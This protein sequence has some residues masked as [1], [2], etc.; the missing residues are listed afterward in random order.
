MGST[1]LSRMA[2]RNLWRSPRRSGLTLSSIAF[3][4]LLAVL[5][6]GMGDANFSA[7]IDLA[8]R[9][10]GGH[11]A[12]QNVR[13]LDAPTLTHAIAG[14]QELRRAVLQDP[15]VAKVVVRVTGQ[16]MLQT[17]E[18]SYGAAYLAIDPA[19]EDSQTLS[20]LD[21]KIEGELFQS[22]AERGIILG[23]RLADNLE[24]GLGRK[25]VYLLTDRHG[26]I[27]RDVARVTATLHTGSPSVDAGLCL[28]PID[29]LRK[30]VG[31][32]PGEAT[33]LGLF[34][35]DQRDAD[36]VAQR[37]GRALPVDVTA[38]PWHA[39]HPD[40][41]GFIAMKVASARLMEGIIMVLVAAGIFNTLFVSVME[42]VRE[43][44]ILMAIGFSQRS[45]FGLVMLES[46][47]LGGLGL[48]AAALLTAGPYWWLATRGLDVS[49][50]LG[51]AGS[52]VAGVGV[53]PIL[54]V[55]IFGEH[56]VVIALA[57][58]GATLLAGLYPAWRAGRF[59]PVEAVRRV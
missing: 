58:L 56:L 26:G 34:L 44:G 53:S 22:S 4:T 31:Y 14:A 15:D 36:R 43:F 24:T 52:E 54:Y 42:R 6:T 8:A 49:S 17:A 16:L 33:R 47:W 59:D 32:S 13:T 40:L 3:G 50:Y 37:L 25:V 46:L 5:F 12:V 28:L 23:D 48:V 35:R 7:M 29:T 27:V 38:L 20:I 11:V 9:L 39:L 57:A 19:L 18:Q 10:G 41:A 30:L 1:S 45:L 51:D 21:A 55:G 2:W